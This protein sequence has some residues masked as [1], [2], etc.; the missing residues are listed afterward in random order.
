M[1]YHCCLELYTKESLINTTFPYLMC[2][3]KVEKNK[4]T[5]KK[6]LPNLYAV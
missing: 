3:N 1:K 6:Y 2:A 5:N 4:N